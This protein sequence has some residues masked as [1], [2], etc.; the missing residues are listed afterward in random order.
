MRIIESI[1]NRCSLLRDDSVHN[2]NQMSFPAP[3]WKA[4]EIF[5]L[6][7]TELILLLYSYQIQDLYNSKFWR[8]CHCYNFTIYA[9]FNW[10]PLHIYLYIYLYIYVNVCT[11]V[12]IHIYLHL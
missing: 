6:K 9:F 3:L 10:L 8:V 11:Q 1:S 2:L 5:W 12:N 7:G 4:S